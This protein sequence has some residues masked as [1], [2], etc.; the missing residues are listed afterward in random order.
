MNSPYVYLMNWYYISGF[1]DADGCVTAIRDRKGKN[2]TLQISFTN[3]ELEILESIKLFIQNE[4]D[5]TGSISRKKARQATH[6][7]S[8]ELKYVF[9]NATNVAEKII[10]LHPKKKHRIE[11]YKKIQ[12]ATKRNGKYTEEED[13]LRDSLM[14]EFFKHS[15]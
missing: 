9:R 6:S 8:F 7:D 5:C 15:G 1:F 4:I 2:K 3:N 13:M 12:E 14:S 11:V 10:S